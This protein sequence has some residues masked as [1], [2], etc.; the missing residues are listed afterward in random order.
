MVPCTCT[1][2]CTEPELKAILKGKMEKKNEELKI[3]KKR[4][5]CTMLCT[6]TDQCRK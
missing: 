2:Q 5:H 4:F 6:C 3:N 1:N